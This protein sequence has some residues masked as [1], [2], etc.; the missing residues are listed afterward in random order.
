MPTKLEEVLIEHNHEMAFYRT[1][2]GFLNL[3]VSGIIALKIFTII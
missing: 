3:L 2:F 1:I